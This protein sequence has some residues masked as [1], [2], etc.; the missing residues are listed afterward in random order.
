MTNQ[1]QT[2]SIQQQIVQ[3][4]AD[5]TPL[6]I[7]GSGSHQFMLPEFEESL[8]IE[9]QHHTG[10]IDYQPTELTLKARSGTPISTLTP[11][12][13]ENQQRLPT[14]FPEYAEGCTLGGAIA[15]GHSGSGRPFHGAIRDH[16]LGATLING[17]AELVQCGGQVMKNVAGY[18]VSR[19]L[20]GS[21]GTL[22]PVLDITLKV[23]P[24]P[25]TQLTLIYD[26]D[27]HAA[28]QT[29]N[30]MAGQALPI[31]AA[32]FYQQQLIIRLQGTESGVR[33]AQQNIGGEIMPQEHDFWSGIQ[34]Q[35][36]AFFKNAGT[37]WRIIVP[38]TAPPLQ[39]ENEHQSLIDWCGGLRWIDCD[40]IT[41]T[42]RDHIRQLGGYIE[43]H[44]GAEATPPE[45]LMSN[46]QQKMQRKIKQA[47]DPEYLFNPRLSPR[48]KAFDD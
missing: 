8:K 46:L 12:L 14:D 41:I 40:T 4:A 36:H 22:G 38:A 18:D 44:K 11:L 10:I 13:Q 30:Q 26:K 37:L 27:M 29:M 6:S 17:H 45:S 19:M 1:D 42:D 33:H 2:Q 28:I 39:L 20:C 7:H 15:I 43:A 23:L 24:Q 16:V 35:S 34:Q 5:N 47:F 48:T 21:R 25:E 32:V 9:M 3:A 31:T